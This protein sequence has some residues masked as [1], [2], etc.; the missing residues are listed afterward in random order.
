M[1]KRRWLERRQLRLNSDILPAMKVLF[2]PDNRLRVKTKPVKKIDN[3]LRAVIKEMVKLTLSFKDPEGVGLA[4]TQVGNDE[5]Y[6]VAKLDKKRF[7]A[8]F[9]PKILEHAKETKPFFEGCLSVPNYWGEVDRYPWVKVSYLDEDGKEVK[10]KLTGLL[11]HIFQHEVDH[12]NGK[13]FVDLVLEK[14]T[15]LYKVVGKDRAG[16]EIYQEVSF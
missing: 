1:I 12:L 2:V 4:S 5:Q 15:K 13:L 10:E 11:A 16:A 9:N 3:G 14:K 6:F 8:Y 7:K